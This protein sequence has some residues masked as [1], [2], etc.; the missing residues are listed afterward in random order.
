MTSDNTVAKLDA[1]DHINMTLVV[2]SFTKPKARLVELK[3]TLDFMQIVLG[4]EVSP[5]VP[6]VKQ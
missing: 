1:S 2:F 4:F 6:Y 5:N 3:S